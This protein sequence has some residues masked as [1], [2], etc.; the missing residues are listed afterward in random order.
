MKFFSGR[1]RREEELDEE[2][3]GHLRMAIQD[4]IERGETP[5]QA[6]ASARREFGNVTLV[7]EVT[8]G[9]WGWAW[10][11]GCARDVRYGLRTMRREPAFAAVAVLTLALGIGANT[12]IFS[13]VN[14]VLLRGLPF[15]KSD[16][17]V[18]VNDENGKTGEVLPG[19]SPADFFDSKAQTQSFAGFAA[20][21]GWSVTLLDAD[22]PEVI[23]AARVTDEFFDALQV[24]PLLGRPFRPEE[25]K[26]GSNVIILS[27]RLWQRRF[28]GDPGIVGRTLP[29][30]EGGLTVVGVM[31]PDFKL[32][33]TAEAWTPVAQDSSEMRLRASRYFQAVARLKPGVSRE[34]AEAEMRTIAARLAGQ[35]P[36]SN[37]NWSVR[38]APLREAL[39]GD[40]RPALLILFG[41]VGL[42]LLIA[43]A[44]V[45]NLLLARA[46]A[47]Y[48]EVAIRAALGA[49]H[50]R[51]LR[52]LVIES[53]LLSMVGGA[54]GA[55]LAWWGVGAILW[56][57]PKDLR[58][59]RMED[60][61][62]DPLVLGFTFA[63]AL[64]TGVALGLIPGLKASRGDFQG[65]LKESGQRAT[66]GRRLRRT[67]GAVV[68]AE[69]ALTLVLLAGAGL[70]IK[71]LERLQRVELGFNP[72]NVLV[73]P[74]SAS[75]S[76]YPEPQARA[77]YFERLAEQVRTTPGVEAV[78]TAS[79]APMMYTMYFPF[80]IEGRADPNEAPQA[81]YNS[82]S[83][84][85][86]RLMGIGLVEGREFSEHDRVGA[87]NAAV[88]NETMRR[89]F[90]A[91]ED[92]LGKRLT[93][94]YL[95]A[96]LAVE[97]V[98]VVK[99]IKQESL[100]APPNAQIYVPS[101]QVPWFSTAL[102]IRAKDDPAA[103]LPAVE[104]ALR[105]AD[106]TQPG[107]GAKT[108]AQ[109]L[110]DSA[111][112]PRFYGLLL[113]VFA[114]LALLLAAV[115]V[116]GLISYAV[117][118]RTHEIGVRMA[119]GARAGDVLKLVVGEGMLLVLAGLALGLGAAFVLTR[120]MKS[121][122]Y[123]VGATDPVTF[124]GVTALLA[125]VALA[126]CVIPA[127]RAT[128]VDPVT[129]LRCE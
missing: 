128:R 64:L 52:Q 116:Y 106:P 86:F 71:S 34:Q 38:L 114:G 39:V 58:F 17:L 45:A 51:I 9:M 59:P 73:M 48:R 113:G 27:H 62:V 108:M 21:S 33:S 110:S 85:Y 96:P 88:I 32:P 41:A 61:R 12:A 76:K 40:V 122:L 107:S 111:A 28:G 55:L 121:L 5:E 77:A 3:R 74:V 125:A 22:R 72:D 129:A 84:G 26:G 31:P 6:E 90:F 56:L 70:L 60:A 123:E 49:S 66:A 16:E 25:Y 69:I 75:M 105:S 18:V 112:Q 94:N 100:A 43:C 36:E 109:L 103:V 63:V 82:V 95:N 7:K 117:A 104:R 101:S 93:I 2:L 29:V 53:V 46:T 67:R 87:P 50:W 92:P 89:R 115:G 35:Y 126:A 54:L 79:C 23:P 24:M 14:A 80:S 118:Q 30:E 4:R 119:L 15:P 91:G 13:V 10:L 124:A 127:R 102:V 97:V 19:V 37:S 44:N 42:V 1:R 8:R 65:S 57:V 47:R 83:P 98:C 99:D 11:L 78:A 20:H 120:L 81:W 68:V